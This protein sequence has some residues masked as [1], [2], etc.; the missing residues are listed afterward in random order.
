VPND[1]SSERFPSKRGHDERVH[2]EGS[3]RHLF[4]SAMVLKHGVRNSV[5]PFRSGGRSVTFTISMNT[6]PCT[7]LPA[8]ENWYARAASDFR[9]KRASRSRFFLF[10]TISGFVR[11][12]VSSEVSSSL[13]ASSDSFVGTCGRSSSSSP[14]QT[15][16][17]NFW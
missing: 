9:F 12:S 1:R 8:P 2:V 10:S 15:K 13:S 7:P 5:I 3:T 11:S 6:I 4:K 16:L 17:L 14:A